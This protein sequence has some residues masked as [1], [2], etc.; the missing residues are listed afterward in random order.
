MLNTDRSVHA[1]STTHSWGRAQGLPT[2]ILRVNHERCCG[3]AA[4]KDKARF[5][6]RI[7]A[8]LLRTRH[9]RCTVR[10]AWEQPNISMG[11]DWHFPTSLGWPVSH[12]QGKG[13][14]EAVFTLWTSISPEIYNCLPL[15]LIS[16]LCKYG[17]CSTAVRMDMWPV[18]TYICILRYTYSVPSPIWRACCF[19]HCCFCIK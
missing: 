6:V 11:C 4:L 1:S 17:Q 16:F 2:D 7:R 14:G 18:E 19:F 12:C 9:Q 10:R 3:A 8:R 13:W 15:S 5:K